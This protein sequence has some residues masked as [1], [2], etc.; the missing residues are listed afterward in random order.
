[1]I[2]QLTHPL[3][4]KKTMQEAIPTLE[5]ESL[6][7]QIPH[8][9]VAERTSLREYLESFLVTIILGL[10]GNELCRAGFKIPSQSWEPTLLIGDHLLVNKSSSRREGYLVRQDSAVPGR[11][12]RRHHRLQVSI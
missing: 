8:A 5:A 10:F 2:E 1:V 3:L 6:P 11:S 7:A 4:T 9:E 12:P